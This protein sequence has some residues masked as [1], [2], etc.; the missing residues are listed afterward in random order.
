MA[1]TDTFVKGVKPSMVR[2]LAAFKFLTYTQLWQ[3]SLSQF[4]P[5]NPSEI[6]QSFKLD[7]HKVVDLYGSP[8]GPA[9]HL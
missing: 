5:A 1:L 6:G 2:G 9:D 4:C 7:V 3:V 8:S